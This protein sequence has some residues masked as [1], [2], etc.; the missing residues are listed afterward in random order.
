VNLLVSLNGIWQAAETDYTVTGST[1]TFTAAP[2]AS[3]LVFAVAGLP[4]LMTTAAATTTTT[5]TTTVTT[6][7]PA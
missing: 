3:S 4:A 1:V 2:Q 6:E 7:A 5:T